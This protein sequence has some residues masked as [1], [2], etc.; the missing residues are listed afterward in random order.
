MTLNRPGPRT[1]KNVPIWDR[2]YHPYANND[3]HYNIA[4]IEKLIVVDLRTMRLA[5]ESVANDSIQ[6]KIFLVLAPKN[7]PN[8]L[9]FPGIVYPLDFGPTD[10]PPVIARTLSDRYK[11]MYSQRTSIC[12]FIARVRNTLARWQIA[13][14]ESPHITLY[15]FRGPHIVPA[16]VKREIFFRVLHPCHNSLVTRAEA[17][18]LRGACYSLRRSGQDQVAEAMDR[19]LCTPQYNDFHCRS[20]LERGLLDDRRRKESA[21]RIF[22]DHK[23]N[24][25]GDQYDLNEEEYMAED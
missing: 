14:C 16:R 12:R 5:T 20:L 8:G 11:Q 3:A 22:E 2:K 17:C 21:A 6:T 1:N 18:F 7:A 9:L 15:T 10:L 4:R 13:E 19:M 24:A 25:I 23:S